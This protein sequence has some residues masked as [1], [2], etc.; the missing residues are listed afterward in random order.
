MLSVIICTYNRS[1]ILKGCLESL[2][3]QTALKDQYEVLIIDN[4]SPD[5]TKEICEEFTSNNQN[6]R[7]TNP[8]ITYH[9]DTHTENISD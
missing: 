1:S 6:I 5:N 2:V 3:D 9:F 7:Y 8:D 4:N